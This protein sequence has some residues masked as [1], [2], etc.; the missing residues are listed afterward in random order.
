[1]A[2]DRKRRG[3]E[4]G[5]ADTVEIRIKVGADCEHATVGVLELA[6]MQIRQVSD[7]LALE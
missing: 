6:A 1:M 2:N 7:S 3:A 5:R 4:S